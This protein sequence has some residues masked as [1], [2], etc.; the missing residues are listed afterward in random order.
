MRINNLIVH[1]LLTSVIVLVVVSTS[2]IAADCPKDMKAVMIDD[3]TVPVA[4]LA[5]RVNPLTK[6][7]LEA[8]ANAWLLVLQE[9]A[10]EISNAEVVS[11]IEN[12]QVFGHCSSA[13]LMA[14]KTD[15]SVKD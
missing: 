12:M 11:I 7:E 14:T 15:D 5:L 1:W 4:V 6:C 3:A 8:E 2:A 10:V 9:K 13:D